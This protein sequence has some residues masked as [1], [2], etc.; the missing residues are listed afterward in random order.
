MIFSILSRVPLKSMSRFRCVSSEWR[1]IISDPNFVAEHKSRQKNLVGAVFLQNEDPSK[2]HYLKL[3]DIDGNVASR[4][5]I[6]YGGGSCRKLCGSCI[7]ALVRIPDDYSGVIE[8]GKDLFQMLYGRSLDLSE[9][10]RNY[11]FQMC[12]ICRC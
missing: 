3:V 8:V 5:V 7:H 1:D 6:K 4:R 12:A 9:R 11:D 10:N 2:D